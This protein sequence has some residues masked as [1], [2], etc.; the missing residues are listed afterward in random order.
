MESQWYHPGIMI[1][2]KDCEVVH[3]NKRSR[4]FEKYL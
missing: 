1:Y 2:T 4:V 3:L